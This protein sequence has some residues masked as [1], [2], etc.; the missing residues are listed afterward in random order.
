MKFKTDR[1]LA[2]PEAAEKKLLEIANAI[3]A[4]HACRLSVAAINIRNFEMQAATPRSSSEEQITLM[5]LDPCSAAF[6]G[7]E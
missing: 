6:V 1:T 4:D 5:V 7:V 3:G 2:T